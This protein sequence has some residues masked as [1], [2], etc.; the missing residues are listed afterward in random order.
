MYPLFRLNSIKLHWHYIIINLK[1][2]GNWQPEITWNSSSNFS[3]SFLM[4]CMM[5]LQFVFFHYFF[6]PDRDGHYFTE[7]V[8]E[9]LG[10]PLKKIMVLTFAWGIPMWA[11]LFQCNRNIFG[12]K[13]PSEWTILPSRCPYSSP[14][15]NLTAWVF[16]R[17]PKESLI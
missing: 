16:R 9:A 3:R 5:S 6:C 2:K 17:K 10:Y 4:F 15:I 7:R 13:T 11:Q 14:N 12:N 8:E 1:N